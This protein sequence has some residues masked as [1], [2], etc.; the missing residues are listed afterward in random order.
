M[1]ALVG[2]FLMGFAISLNVYSRFGTDPYT[3]L[4]LGISSKLGISLGIWQ[5]SLNL[6][7][8]VVL[9]VFARRLVGI[10]TIANMI[11]I[12]FLVDFFS[13]IYKHIL[14]ENPSLA[15]RIFMMLA[16]VVLL[17]FTVALYMYPDEGVSPYD[18]IPMLLT[19]KLKFP[20]QWVRIVWDVSAVAIGWLCGSVVGVGTVI[21]AFGLGPLIKFFLG[22]VEKWFPIEKEPVVQSEKI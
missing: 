2:V 22:L 21:L 16:G 5:L 17:A 8:L 6:V 20:Y 18:G 15:L 7:L 4:N 12:G 13:G 19:E 11:G 14:P 1:M 3:C 9:F 10:G